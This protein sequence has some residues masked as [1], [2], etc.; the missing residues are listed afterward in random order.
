MLPS[1]TGSLS[2][3]VFLTAASQSKPSPATFPQPREVTTRQEVIPG[4]ICVW[5]SLLEPSPSSAAHAPCLTRVSGYPTL[6]SPCLE[7]PSSP[8]SVGKPLPLRK[9]ARVCMC[10][11]VCSF[12]A[13][14]GC[15][16]DT[17]KALTPCSGGDHGHCT[18]AGD[19]AVG[20]QDALWQLCCQQAPPS[21]QQLG[22]YFHFSLPAG[23]TLGTALFRSL[24]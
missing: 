2:E 18:N 3:D 20:A 22:L 23:S 1:A 6:A 15:G 10:L 12:P 14:W 24:L 9:Q 17:P 16:K 8:P 19:G 21:D 5:A 13:P 7:Q 4:G 11:R